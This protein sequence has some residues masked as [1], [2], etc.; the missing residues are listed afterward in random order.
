M[1]IHRRQ[2]E[3]GRGFPK[4]WPFFPKAIMEDRD[5][6]GPRILP[7]LP[8][9]FL[10]DCSLLDQPGR[11]AEILHRRH[12]A[13]YC[14]WPLHPIICQDRLSSRKFFGMLSLAGKFN[15]RPPDSLGVGTAA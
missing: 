13:L 4:F 15:N 11:L 8:K 12:F 9:I 1:G 5:D 3:K 7:S 2:P 10:L 14:R 6:L